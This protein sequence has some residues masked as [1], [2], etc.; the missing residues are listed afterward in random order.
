[1]PSRSGSGRGRVF[2]ETSDRSSVIGFRAEDHSGDTEDLD[3][4]IET[5]IF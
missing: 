2:S 3:L 1:L 5:A 4:L